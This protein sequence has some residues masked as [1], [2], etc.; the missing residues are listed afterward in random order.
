MINNE[1]QEKGDDGHDLLQME[2]VMAQGYG[3]MPKVVMRD[4][5]LTVDAKAI[6]AYMVSFAGAGQTAFP[7]RATILADLCISKTSF[8][9]HFQLLLDHDY[10][11]IKRQKVGN[12]LGRNIY[13]LVMVPDEAEGSEKSSVSRC[14]INQDID[15]KPFTKTS[16]SQNIGQRKRFLKNA[17][18]S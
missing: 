13:T 8:Y 7:K 3:I 5:R 2:G 1:R 16:M 11:R 18:M 12:L 17:S 4:R 9:K 6:Y 14:P 10:I 15:R